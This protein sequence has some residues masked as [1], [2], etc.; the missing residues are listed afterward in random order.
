VGL[1]PGFDAPKSTKPVKERKATKTAP[2]LIFEAHNEGAVE[3]AIYGDENLITVTIDATG[4]QYQGKGMDKP[5]SIPWDQV[6]DWQAN[7][8]TS[9]NPARA[10]AG[11]YGIGIHQGTRY[12]SFRTRNG[13][14]FTAAVKALRAKAFS[15]ERPGIG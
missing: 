1:S 2:P 11:D 14:D 6:T 4:I 9:H 10:V 8:F 13:R 5:L 12:F 7:N 15:K 3:G